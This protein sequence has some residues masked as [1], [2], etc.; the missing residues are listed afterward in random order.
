MTNHLYAPTHRGSADSD[1]SPNGGKGRERWERR[2]NGGDG[3]GLG[4]EWDGE[5]AGTA[6][7]SG[8]GGNG[9]GKPSGNGAGAP[10]ARRD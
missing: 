7:L 3:A 2:G 5:E 8:N 1:G 10:L 9:P 6:G 4:R